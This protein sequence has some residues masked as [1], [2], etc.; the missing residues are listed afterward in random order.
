[1]PVTTAAGT[2]ISISAA[3]PATFDAAGYTAS[4]MVFTPIGEITDGGE[5]GR[6][7]SEVTHTPLAKRGTQKFK[8]SFNEGT[9]QLALAIDDDDAGQLLAE[10]ALDSDDNY[11][12]EIRY[13]SGRRDYFQAK[14]MSFKTSTPGTD[15]VVA[16]TIS[17]SIT[18]NSDGIGVVKVPAP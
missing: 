17:L 10:A 3:T 4:P 2:I 16:G 5:H 14:V 8:G 18:T 13:P 7:Y 11:S 1:M 12:F 6:E 15:S 9:K